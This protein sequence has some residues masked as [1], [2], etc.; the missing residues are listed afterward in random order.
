MGTKEEINRLF[1]KLIDETI[2]AE[3]LNLFY[4]YVKQAKNDLDLQRHL[5]SLEGYVEFRFE[6]FDDFMEKLWKGI[7]QKFWT[8]SPR[9]SIFSFKKLTF[10]IFFY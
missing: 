5:A 10:I 2:T 8:F 9:I 1:Q 6:S 4:T 3:E 7:V